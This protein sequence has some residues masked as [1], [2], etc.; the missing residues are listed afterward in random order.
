[1]IST[2][3]YVT[4]ALFM[5]LAVATSLLGDDADDAARDLKKMQG[6]WTFK[7]RDGSDST[8]IFKDDTL[9]VKSPSRSYTS[10]IKLDPKAKPY[11]A[12]DIRVTEGPEDAKGM[13]SLGIYQFDGES[14]LT[15]CINGGDSPRPAALESAEGQ[16][17]L[18]KLK[19][20]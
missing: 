11:P 16:S 3:R 12:I 15:I 6:S 14:A 17:Y 4:A 8:W 18:F 13:T 19:K 1:M 5:M 2:P 7:T 10:K 20:K 9:S